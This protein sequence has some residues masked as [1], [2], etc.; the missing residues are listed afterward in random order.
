MALKTNTAEGR[1]TGTAHQLF[2]PMLLSSLLS[3][4]CS[5]IGGARRICNNWG[6][7]SMLG[8]LTASPVT[9]ATTPEFLKDEWE[10]LRGL[11]HSLLGTCNWGEVLLCQ[12]VQKKLHDTS[13]SF[14]RFDRPY[15]ALYLSACLSSFFRAFFTL[16]VSFEIILGRLIFAILLVIC[17]AMSLI[18]LEFSPA[19]LKIALK[20]SQFKSQILPNISVS[21]CIC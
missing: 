4:G 17:Q 5:T 2:M 9:N 11:L 3:L 13:D 1:W 21:S 12:P 18:F 6:A 7:S 8:G 19:L 10:K 14:Q 15:N 20:G 16:V